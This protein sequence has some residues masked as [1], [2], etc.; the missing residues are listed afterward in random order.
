MLLSIAFIVL[1]QLQRASL[2]VETKELDSSGCAFAILL[3]GC[4]LVALVCEAVRY[5]WP[6]PV[7]SVIRVAYAIPNKFGSVW[8]IFTELGRWIVDMLPGMVHR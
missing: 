8:Q 1:Y 3:V 2:T 6:L 7:I 5:R 4:V